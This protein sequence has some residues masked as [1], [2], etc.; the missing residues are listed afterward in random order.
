MERN[1]DGEPYHK[2][3][4]ESDATPSVVS[5]PSSLLQASSRPA[6][7]GR[8]STLGV[9]VLVGVVVAVSLAVARRRGVEFRRLAVVGGVAYAVTLVGFWLAIR[10]L[11]WRLDLELLGSV[12]VSVPLAAVGVLLSCQWCVAV[13]GFVRYRLSTAVVWVFGLTTFTVDAFATVGGEGGPVVFLLFWLF[14]VGPASLIG[15]LAVTSSEY[16][17]GTHVLDSS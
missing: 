4:A 6:V 12:W 8:A 13:V 1:P 9:A 14:A 7:G 15:L 11:F 17:V 3:F 5:V 2:A 10:V 16:L